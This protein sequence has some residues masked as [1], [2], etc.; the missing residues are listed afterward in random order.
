M[1]PSKIGDGD[2]IGQVH[3]DQGSIEFHPEAGDIIVRRILGH[4][5]SG[6]NY[7]QTNVRLAT[8]CIVELYKDM[9]YC[10]PERCQDHAKREAYYRMFFRN[11][12][13][14]IRRGQFDLELNYQYRDHEFIRIWVYWP[15]YHEHSSFVRLTSRCRNMHPVRL[16][17][18]V[19]GPHRCRAQTLRFDED[20][21]YWSPGDLVLRFFEPGPPGV[22]NPG[23]DR[24]VGVQMV[25]ENSELKFLKVDDLLIKMHGRPEPPT[26]LGDPPRP[27]TRL[28]VYCYALTKGDHGHILDP[29]DPFDEMEKTD[30]WMYLCGDSMLYDFNDWNS[31]MR[32]PTEA[33]VPQ[34]A[35]IMISINEQF[36][37]FNSQTGLGGYVKFYQHAPTS[38]DPQLSRAPPVFHPPRIPP[39]GSST[40]EGPAP[41]LPSPERDAGWLEPTWNHLPVPVPEAAHPVIFRFGRW[42]PENGTDAFPAHRWIWHPYVEIFQRHPRSFDG[43]M[44]F[45]SDRT[46]IYYGSGIEHPAWEEFD[47]ET[48]LYKEYLMDDFVVLV[49]DCVIRRDL[50]HNMHPVLTHGL[51]PCTNAVGDVNIC[52]GDW[53]VRY[54]LIREDHSVSHG[55]VQAHEAPVNGNRYHFGVELY[56]NTLDE[57]GIGVWQ[58]RG[59]D[60]VIFGTIDQRP[61]VKKHRGQADTCRL[62]G[63]YDGSPYTYDAPGSLTSLCRVLV[64]GAVAGGVTAAQRDHQEGDDGKGKNEDHGSAASTSKEK[65][66]STIKARNETDAIFPGVQKLGLQDEASSSNRDYNKDVN[67]DKKENDIKNSK[68]RTI[69]V[70]PSR[71]RVVS[72]L[73]IPSFTPYETGNYRR[74][75]RGNY[76]GTI[77]QV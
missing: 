20:E 5:A 48:E 50:R 21:L 59:R 2:F 12:D 29:D 73:L 15:G 3:H 44:F 10:F 24:L 39:D 25:D 17:E 35:D 49:G 67:L 40:S 47:Q 46:E 63:F 19:I 41:N 62:T 31:V 8:S 34:P 28:E 1:N 26:I 56:V 9:Y 38:V 54:G 7:H 36:V 65:K 4:E 58:F 69:T 42:A 64:T 52:P 55:A 53:L 66:R 76:D 71:E 22:P 68:M 45:R 37:P 72:R 70:E 32:F 27:N 77:D 13:H 57:D 16:Y 14:I 75:F 60:Q 30:R 33:A 6:E 61:A 18:P 43:K 23:W 74:D 11:G 51:L